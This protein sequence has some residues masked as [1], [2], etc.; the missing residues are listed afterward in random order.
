[1]RMV[2]RLS[3]RP[4][5][6]WKPA[7]RGTRVHLR[8]ALRESAKLAGDVVELRYRTRRLRRTSLVVLC[9]VSGSMDLYS[10]FL[11]QFIYALQRS[12]ARVES[13]TFSTRLA[14][15][16]STSAAGRIGTRSTACRVTP[17]DGRAERASARA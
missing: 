11:L 9:D 12:F 15:T 13:F 5:R 14:R 6:R 4:S 2:R 10:R 3:S 8:G 7:R 16:P 17:A 1:M